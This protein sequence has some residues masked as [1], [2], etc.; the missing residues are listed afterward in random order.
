MTTLADFLETLREK[1]VDSK[2]ERYN[3]ESPDYVNGRESMLE[4][5]IYELEELVQN[6]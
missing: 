3:F 2:H 6:S 5:I 1:L 4:S